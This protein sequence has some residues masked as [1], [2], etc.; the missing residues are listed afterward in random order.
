MCL[1]LQ[2]DMY[3]NTSM[4]LFK[5]I[6][7]YVRICVAHLLSRPKPSW[8]LQS[9]RPTFGRKSCQIKRLGNWDPICSVRSDTFATWQQ[10]LLKPGPILQGVERFQ[11]SMEAGIRISH[12]TRSGNKISSNT[13]QILT[14]S[15]MIRRSAWCFLHVRFY[16]K[17]GSSLPGWQ[18][19][20]VPS[21]CEDFWSILATA[22]SEHRM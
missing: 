5:Y 18:I 22:Q 2:R 15:S 21:L 12:N 17:V 20:N 1:V 3:M 14:G 10:F 7:V 8:I 16:T 6:Q 9:L 4:H 11:D 13:P 19:K